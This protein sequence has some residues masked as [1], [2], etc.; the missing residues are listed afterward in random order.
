MLVQE[1]FSIRELPT[2]RGTGGNGQYCKKLINISLHFLLLR[3][4]P[5]EEAN[6]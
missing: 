1:T 3:T 2:S 5:L 6:E 4:I